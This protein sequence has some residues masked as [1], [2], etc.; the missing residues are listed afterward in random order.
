MGLMP[1][2]PIHALRASLALHM[3]QVLTPEVCAAIELAVLRPATPVTVPSVLDVLPEALRAKLLNA[4][5]RAAPRPIPWA[6][7]AARVACGHWRMVLQGGGVALVEH[8]MF[9]GSPVTSIVAM[10][11][12][13]DACRHLVR[14]IEQQ[15]AEHGSECVAF[16]GRRGWT[17]AFPDYIERSSVGVK[18]LP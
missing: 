17:R 15:A 12:D 3:G 5:E 18:E 13:L 10:A 16:I 14:D 1:P 11:G 9:V 7:A 4:L 2:T 6:D 8:A